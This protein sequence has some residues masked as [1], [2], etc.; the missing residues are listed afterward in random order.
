MDK[1]STGGLKDIYEMSQSEIGEKLFLKQ[2][3]IQKIEKK[4]I[5][6]LK[7]A[8]RNRNIDPKDLLND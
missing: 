7:Q 3:T 4:A 2:Q 1:T 6:S 8:F 5:E